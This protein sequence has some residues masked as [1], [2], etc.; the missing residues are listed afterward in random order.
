[1]N[2]VDPQTYEHDAAD[3]EV[4]AE[5]F[6]HAAIFAPPDPEVFH[7]IVDQHLA[8]EVANKTV[9]TAR[10]KSRAAQ[11]L[12]AYDSLRID[13]WVRQIAHTPHPVE[14]V[15]VI[16]ASEHEALSRF[17]AAVETLR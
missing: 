10:L 4:T 9:E 5:P 13:T 14:G 8:I 16:P 11:V 6:V 17:L 3:V 1:M 15:I 12:Q 7:S 2:S